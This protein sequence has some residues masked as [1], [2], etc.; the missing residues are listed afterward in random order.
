MILKKTSYESWAVGKLPGGC[1]FCVEGKKLVLFITGKCPRKCY[2]CPL[3]ESRKNKDVVYANERKLSDATAISEAIEEAKL[4]DAKGMG[5]TGGDPLLVI[6]RTC[7][8]VKAFKRAFGK[9]FHIHIYLPTLLTNEKNLKQLA[10]SGIDEVRFHPDFLNFDNPTIRAREIEKI[11]LANKYG[12]KVGCE[13][14]VIPKTEDKMILF[15]YSVRNYISFLN[16]NELETSVG[17]A[18]GFLKKKFVIYGNT[19]VKGSRESALKVIKWASRNLKNCKLKQLHY[20]SARTKDFFQ[21]RNRLKRRLKL[22]FKPYDQVTTNDTLYRAALYPKL[23]VNLEKLRKKLMEEFSIPSKLI[24]VDSNKKRI[25]TSAEI[26]DKLKKELK[27]MNLKIEIVEEL[28]TY[29][30]IEIQ[31]ESI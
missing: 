22:V 4:M 17:N 13:I 29:D 9:K 28:P 7:R 26:A 5:I 16:L 8:Y 10:K 27:K 11:N 31:S 19:A 14:P 15:A 25:L 6:D 1:Q 30:T 12:W 3:S 2:Y 20:C 21:Y 18:P 23:N 24:E